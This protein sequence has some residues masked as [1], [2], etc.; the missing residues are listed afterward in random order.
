MKDESDFNENNTASAVMGKMANGTTDADFARAIGECIDAVQ[1]TL[2]K[3]KLTLTI[4]MEPRDD[5]GCIELRA[6]IVTKLP[7][8]KAP[9]TQMHVGPAGELM[10]QSDFLLF[11]GRSETA[12]KP[13]PQQ[14]CT[15]SGRLPVAAAPAPA[16]L[17]AA[18]AM[19]PV[20][21]AP[22]T[23]NANVGKDAAVGKDS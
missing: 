18:P 19:A 14:R 23:T 20:A 15:A 17:A 7:K 11:G 8:L 13:L 6:E 10:T 2:K 12:P 3:A 5:L 21:S 1:N 16:P 9:A 4:D 22:A